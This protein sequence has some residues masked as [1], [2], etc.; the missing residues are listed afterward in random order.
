[1]KTF[2]LTIFAAIAF[3]VCGCNA[4]DKAQPVN[5]TKPQDLSKA[6]KEELA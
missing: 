6:S 2:S 1:M 4:E 5:D 3:A